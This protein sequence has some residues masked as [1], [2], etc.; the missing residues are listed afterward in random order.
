VS[1]ELHATLRANQTSGAVGLIAQNGEPSKIAASK[2][3]DYYLPRCASATIAFSFA[4]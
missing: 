2:R 4:R 3:R 1:N